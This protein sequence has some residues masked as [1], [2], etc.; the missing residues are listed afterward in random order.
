MILTTP[1]PSR[2]CSQAGS[3]FFDSAASFAMISGGHINLSI[4][5]AMQACCH[6]IITDLAVLDVTDDGLKRVELPRA[7]VKHNRPLGLAGQREQ[8]A[9]TRNAQLAVQALD[10]GGGTGALNAHARAY[11]LDVATGEH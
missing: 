4:L 6:R 8:F 10:V 11:G 2:R 9:L 3:S 7:S 5:V 1:L